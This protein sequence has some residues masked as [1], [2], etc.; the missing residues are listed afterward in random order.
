MT[1]RGRSIEREI[2]LKSAL[3]VFAISTLVFSILYFALSSYIVANFDDSLLNRA[4]TLVTLTEND[5][6]QVEFEFA[7]EVMPEYDDVTARPGYFQLWFMDGAV[8]EKSHS[9]KGR[10]LSFPATTGAAPSFDNILLIDGRAGR[11]VS[12]TFTP[13]QDIE[14]DEI[15]DGSPEPPLAQEMHLVVAHGRQDLDRALAQLGWSLGLAGLLL[16][17]SLSFLLRRTVRR[18]MRPLQIMSSQIERLD[19]AQLDAR[20]DL[21]EPPSELQPVVARLNDLLKRLEKAFQKECRFS[22]DVAHELRTPLAE[23]QALADVAPGI[24]ADRSAIARFMNDV[25][26][27]ARQMTSI[28]DTLIGLARSDRDRSDWTVTTFSLRQ[29]ILDVQQAAAA[30]EPSLQIGFKLS[31]PSDVMVTMDDETFRLIMRNLLD[32]AYQYAPPGTSIGCRSL[33]NDHGTVT[34]T[35][36]NLAPNLEPADLE[37]MFDRFWRKD[38]ARTS[39]EHVGLGLSLVQTLT[40][41]LDLTIEVDLDTGMFEIHLA[42]LSLDQSAQNLIENRRV[43]G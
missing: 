36:S 5:L 10:S 23:L 34:L 37:L 26:D 11:Q 14:N 2:F 40:Q 24:A 43:A 25:G 13:R 4:K 19:P 1:D 27:I 6:D 35:L 38:A 21:N 8:F 33:L 20:I 29:A 12:L 32:N 31:V 22:A 18:G 9:L 30:A 28:V 15:L 39:G 7:D 16:A 17:A 41:A 3:S 42:N